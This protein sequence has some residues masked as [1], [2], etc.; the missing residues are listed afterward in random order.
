[1]KTNPCYRCETRSATCRIDC[2]AWAEYVKE[3]DEQYKKK[4][5][6]VEHIHSDYVVNLKRKIKM[7]S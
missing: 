5:N 7:R 6:D 3:R 2:Q 4:L 1:M